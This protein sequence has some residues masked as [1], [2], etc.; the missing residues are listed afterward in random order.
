MQN[1]ISYIDSLKGIGIFIVILGHTYQVPDLLHDIIYSF[2]MPLFFMV[3]GFVYREDHYR[4]YSVVEY[5]K[6]VR[7]VT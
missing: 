3:S 2:H 1:R 6:K 4:Q 7:R 5:L